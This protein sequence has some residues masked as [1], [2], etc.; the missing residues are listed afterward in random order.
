M[1]CLVEVKGKQPGRTQSK[2]PDEGWHDAV[3]F[4]YVTVCY[5]LSLNPKHD[6]C[7]HGDRQLESENT[8]GYRTISPRTRHKKQIQIED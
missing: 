7:E 8:S 2:E 1:G 6:T 5:A 4:V 3:I